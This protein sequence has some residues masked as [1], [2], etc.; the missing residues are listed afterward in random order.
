MNQ[1]FLSET[2]KWLNDLPELKLES[3]SFEAGRAA[4]ITVDMVNGFCH[5]GAL[6]SPR[7]QSIIPAVTRTLTHVYSYGIRHFLLAQDA[8]EPD[9]V[10]FGAFLPHCIRGTLEA[11][12]IPE[13]TGLP[14]FHDMVL[15]PKNSLQTGLNTGLNGWLSAHPEV[16]SFFI[17]G[18]CTDLCVYQL[19]MHLRLQA[20]A[21]QLRRRVIV[22][23]DCTETYDLPVDSA[24]KAGVLPHDAAVLNAVF[25]YHM[26][27][28]GIEIYRAIT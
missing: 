13:I 9:A 18:N 11:E 25:L 1:E 6:A 16:D 2:N 17:V 3:G 12:T 24:I 23:V 10:E 4:V 19:A 15:I 8:H 20:N 27:L 21:C 28:N 26:A 7:V 5:N 14:F 22:P